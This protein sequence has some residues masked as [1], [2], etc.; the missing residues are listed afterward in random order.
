MKQYYPHIGLKRICGLFGKTRQAFYEHGWQQADIQLENAI[1]VTMVKQ[2]RNTMPGVGGVK[3]HKIIKQQLQGHSLLVGRDRFFNLLRQH[4]LLVK[5]RRRYVTTTDSHHHFHKWP[6][7]T[8]AITVEAPFLLWVSDITYIRT[9]NGFLYLSLITDAFSRK[10]V[11]HHLGHRL[12][13]QGPVIALRKA[14]SSL[15][16]GQAG[17]VHHSDRGIQY[18]CDQYVALLQENGIKISMTQSG[19]PYENAMAERVNGILKNEMG[20]GKTFTGYHQAVEATARAID[21]YNR[22]RPH[23]SCDYLTPNQAHLSKGPLKKKWTPKHKTKPILSCKVNPVA[24]RSYC[25]A[26]AVSISGTVK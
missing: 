20:L 7:L 25:K 21:A 6:D 8:F 16:K 24:S 4:D 26:I 10:I 14:I 23:M 1:I 22:I 17:L 19:S 3:L 5:S 9:D 13:A 2:L 15:P 18:C 12:K 11:G